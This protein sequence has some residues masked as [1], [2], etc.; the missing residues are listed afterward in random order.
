MDDTRF[1]KSSDG[2]DLIEEWGVFLH[3]PQII[4]TDFDLIRTEIEN[5]TDR[6]AGNNKGIKN[7]P[8]NLKIYSNKVVD[9]TLVDLPGIAKVLE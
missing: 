1:R 8:I 7:S 6:L 4:F 9:L 5:T 2:T 3:K